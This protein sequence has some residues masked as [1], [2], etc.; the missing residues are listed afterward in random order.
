MAS[1]RDGARSVFTSRLGYSGCFTLIISFAPFAPFG[2][3][4]AFWGLVAGLVI[5]VLFEREAFFG[6][7]REA[8]REE[9]REAETA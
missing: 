1:R 9:L 5:A 6:T 7:L 3:G 2:L 8:K 4:S